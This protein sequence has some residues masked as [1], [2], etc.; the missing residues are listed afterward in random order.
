MAVTAVLWFRNDLRL[1]DNQLFH[2]PQVRAA[3]SLVALF[4]IDPRHFQ[5]SRWGDHLRTGSHR[6]RFLAESLIELDRSLASLNSKLT[7]LA[8]RPED[9]IPSL[10][11][12]HGVLA[13]Q[14]EDTYEE[15]HVEKRVLEGIGPHVTVLQ[16]HHQ[17]LLNRGDLGW[18]PSTFLPMPF[19]KYWHGDCQSVEPRP[20]LPRVNKGDVPLP[21]PTRDQ[22]SGANAVPVNLGALL[23]QMDGTSK[24][25]HRKPTEDEGE[26]VWQGGETAAWAQM[27]AYATP[28]GLGTH[29]QT[30]NRF[31]GT[32]SFSRLSPWLANGCLSPRT[33]YW[34]VF[35]YFKKRKNGGGDPR[36]D[37]FHKYV[38]QL[39]WR[40]YFRFYCAHFGSKVFFLEGGAQKKRPWH[41]DADVEQRWR[42]G[43]TG[44]PIVD[45]LMRE[46]KA[47]GYMSNRGRYLVASYLVFYLGIDW[48]IGA[49]WF[50]SQLLDH[51]V[52]SNYG[53]WASM[54]NVAVDLGSR[55]P[56]G[57]KGRGPSDPRSKGRQGSGGDPWAKGAQTGD[58]V[59]D[60][61]E[62]A[63][64]YDR[65]EVFVR[66]W[67]P[68]V[69]HLPRGHAH[70]P[71]D[72]GNS[73]PRPL[74]VHA[75]NLPKS[76]A[77]GG[78]DGPYGPYY[79]CKRQQ[80]KA[81][82]IEARKVE[83]DK[84]AEQSF[85]LTLSH[86]AKPVRRWV[87]KKNQDRMMA[88]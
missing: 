50:E 69:A 21:P 13:Y 51:D 38:F 81:N 16:H 68:E 1:C 55:Y 85:Y 43:L 37:H 30:R 62:Q 2:Y 59:F 77:T 57:L 88:A 4:C 66:R 25:N 41:R 29:M 35:D 72:L 71:P 34:W 61:W 65:D 48:R 24:M 82:C 80:K 67:V 83:A 15:Q 60:P 33:V 8:G 73:Y 12:E 78:R 87:V 86:E 58:A 70:S 75:L 28:D 47:T 79:S 39:C 3:E 53:E 74:A 23:Q 56:M 6:A 63:A 22:G 76:S 42:E 10:L 20:E 14:Q 46:L 32:N 18:D 9:I 7:V 11:G 49:D 26:F 19:G 84:V 5:Q 44:V 36:F 45:A 54:A 31:H 64:Q 17:T 52:C 40:D 27:R